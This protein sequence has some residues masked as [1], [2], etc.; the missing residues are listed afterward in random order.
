MRRAAAPERR[1]ALCHHFDCDWRARRHSCDWLSLLYS[2]HLRQNLLARDRAELAVEAPGVSCFG[3]AVRRSPSA[4][5]GRRQRQRRQSSANI[6][7]GTRRAD[8]GARDDWK[9]FGFGDSDRDRATAGSGRSG[10][11]HWRWS[12]VGAWPI[13]ALCIFAHSIRKPCRCAIR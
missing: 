10:H 8:V 6:A 4:A 7:V 1:A 9:I 3:S 11:T 2:R 13:G 12:G 5:L